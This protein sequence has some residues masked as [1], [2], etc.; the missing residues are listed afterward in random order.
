M[1]LKRIVAF[2]LA[3]IIISTGCHAAKGPEKPW[4]HGK[5]QVSKD[6]KYLMHEDGTPFF[7]FGDTAWLLPERLDRDEAAYY[8]RRA[9]LA[10]YNVAQ[11]QVLNGV[12]SFNA[13]GQMSHPD[14]WNLEAVKQPGNYGYWDHMDF[15]IDIAESQGM[16]IGM[17]CIWGGLVKGGLMDVEQAKEYGKF[18]AERYGS[19]PN[20]IW[21]IGG[22]LPC[23]VKTEIWDALAES[24][25]SIDSNHLMTFH[26]RGRT[27]SAPVYNSRKWLDFNMYQS[28]H[29]KYNQRTEKDKTYPI[30]DGTE[31]DCWMYADTT[32]KYTPLK[33]VIDGE[34]IYEAIAKGLHSPDA[35]FWNAKDVR[36]YAYWDVFAGCAGHTYGHNAIMQFARPGV[37]GAYFLDTEALPWWKALDDPGYNQM[38]YLKRLIL[39]LPYFERREDQSVVRNNGTRYERLAATRGDDYVLV[40]NHTGRNMDI[41]LSK[42]SGKKKNL[43]WMDASTGALTYLGQCG[44]DV[45]YTPADPQTDGVL[46]AIDSSKNYIKP[47]QKEI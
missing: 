3:I 19:K 43:W 22:D 18:L 1:N 13:Y 2:A 4:R 37:N 28:G 9:S 8:L 47:S 23:E 24:I 27:T 46:I 6:G 34:P 41:D 10:G 20:I 32:R 35:G 5:L 14:G 45:K 44:N 31:E 29:R 40:Y 30:P 26:P 16:Y 17:V 12:P 42:I 38:K 36:R 39:A 11:I 15:I 7:Y 25:K 33:P 21:I